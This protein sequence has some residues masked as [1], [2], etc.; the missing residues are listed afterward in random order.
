[1]PHERRMDPPLTMVRVHGAQWK[2]LAYDRSLMVPGMAAGRGERFGC[3]YFDRA[4]RESLIGA[5]NHN[6][7]L[8]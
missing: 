3:N 4:V 7:I 1:M 8:V 6:G 5:N 2:R